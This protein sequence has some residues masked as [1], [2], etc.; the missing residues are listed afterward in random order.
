MKKHQPL[1]SKKPPAPD[2]NHGLIDEWIANAKPALNPIV[3]ELDKV[4]RQELKDPRYAVK[5]GKA[6]YGSPEFGWCIE[7]VAYDVSVNVVFLNGRQLEEPPDLGDET[8]Y[9]KIRIL[10]EARSA[11]I[12]DWIRQSS[13]LPGWP[14]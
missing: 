10:E 7:L 3:S 9:V 6:Y 14:W 4:I 11:Q 5:W 12:L 8:R 2:P 13:Q 1:S